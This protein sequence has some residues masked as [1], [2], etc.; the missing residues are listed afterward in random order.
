[1]IK[2]CHRS[3]SLSC[4][5]DF[6]T[7]SQNREPVHRDSRQSKTKQTKPPFSSSCFTR[8]ANFRSDRLQ[9]LKHVPAIFEVKMS[10]GQLDSSWRVRRNFHDVMEGE[11]WFELSGF[12]TSQQSLSKDVFE[13]T[14]VNR[15]RTFCILG[16]LTCPY[17]RT[18]HLHT[19]KDTWRDKFGS[20]KAYQIKNGT[21]PVDVRRPKI[22]NVF[23]WAPSSINMN[24]FLQF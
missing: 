21:L 17:L 6:F 1:M 18:N 13:E 24:W 15:K 7:L 4:L 10:P 11:D 8:F 14:H 5:R 16:Q 2:G 20:V 22:I 23:A 12:K 19:R 9:K 3:K